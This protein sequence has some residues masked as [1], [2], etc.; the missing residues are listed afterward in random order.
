MGTAEKITK[1]TVH[2]Y[3]TYLDSIEGRA[4]FEKGVIYDMAGGTNVHS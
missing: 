4:E 1:V 3:L 2:D